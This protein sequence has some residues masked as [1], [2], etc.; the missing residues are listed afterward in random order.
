MWQAGLGVLTVL[1]LVPLAVEKMA[2]F[3]LQEALVVT[4][5][6]AIL[7]IVVLLLVVS[8]VLFQAGIQLAVFWLTSDTGRFGKLSHGP[9]RAPDSIIPPPLQR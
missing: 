2:S 3:M 8:A 9:V 5:L 1:L 4:L 6:V 7:V